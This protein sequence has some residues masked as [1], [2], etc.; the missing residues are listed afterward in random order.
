ML[1][2]NV[3]VSYYKYSPCRNPHPGGGLDG[4]VCAN[5]EWLGGGG[6]STYILRGQLG[7]WYLVVPET[8]NTDEYLEVYYCKCKHL[9]SKQRCQDSQNLRSSSE[10]SI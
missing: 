10:F 1:L 3:H 2:R 7:R 5:K 6:R 4:R 9:N 8:L